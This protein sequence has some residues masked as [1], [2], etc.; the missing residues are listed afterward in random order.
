[1]LVL[2]YCALVVVLIQLL[3]SYQSAARVLEKEILVA[4]GA[5]LAEFASGPHRLVLSLDR[6]RA[7]RAML[8]VIIL[9]HVNIAVCQPALENH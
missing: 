8:P 1:M 3:I 9:G 7:V 4:F 6:L 5:C 2:D